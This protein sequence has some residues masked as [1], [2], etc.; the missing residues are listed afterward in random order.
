MMDDELARMRLISNRLIDE[1]PTLFHRSL[2]RLIDWENRLVCIKGARGTGKTTILRQRAKER[3]G[4]DP[5]AFYVSFDHYW[6]KTHS[7]LEFAEEMHKLGVTHLFVDEVH[8]VE[9]WQT[10][11][12][13][14]HDFYPEMS[15]V[16]SGSSILKMDNREGDL[17]RRQIA[18][19]L[20]GLSFREFLAYEG[21]LDA[22][23]VSLEQLTKEH[24]RLAMDIAKKV[25]ILPL[26]DRYLSMGYY[27]F[28]KT[29]HSG[30]YER[31]TETVE[32]VLDSDYPSVEE[33]TPA[34]IRK[35]KKM[36]AVLAAT[37][38]QQPN[39]SALYRELETDR[40]QG[41]KMLSVLERAGLI[42][43]V[44]SGKDSLKN[45][46]RP[47]KIFCDNPN[48]M[49]ALVSRAD[50]GTIRETFFVNQLRATGHA[51]VCADRGD[52]NVDGRLLFEVGG[53]GKGFS[54]IKDI[55]ESFVAADDLETGFG[56]KIPLWLFG[57]LY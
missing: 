49:H 26:F 47:E 32:K 28:Y 46:S 57:F 56:N 35:T 54:Q 2:Y 19:T 14:F 22:K 7:P 50:K 37:C 43:L 39:M 3:F 29:E 11:I 18:Y 52:F 10:A 24:V 44:P 20:S 33:V 15:V 38:P 30:Y 23:P 9:H 4:L 1:T 12:K 36:L 34:T 42:A 25:R 17:S 8:H 21:V 40:N 55:P 6:F 53:P 45:L 13:N 27:P 41:L 51:V 16:Y 48:L 5:C 31:V